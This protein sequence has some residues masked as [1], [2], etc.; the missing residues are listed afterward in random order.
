[1]ATRKQARENDA[2]TDSERDTLVRPEKK[3]KPEPKPEP[4]FDDA[5]VDV[6]GDFNDKVPIETAD[7]TSTELKKRAR[8]EISKEPP[9]HVKADL[10]SRARSAELQS[11]ARPMS[12]AEQLRQA[13][14][15]PHATSAVMIDGVPQP[16]P[17]VETVRSR[18]QRRGQ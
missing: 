10:L 15:A 1:M 6:S 5:G 16:R 4:I 2:E 17:V 8:A 11:L 12:P 14:S 3:K 18:R 9:E 13:Q 7:G